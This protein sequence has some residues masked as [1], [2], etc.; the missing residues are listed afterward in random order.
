MIGST[1]T[2]FQIV[3]NGPTTFNGA[4]SLACSAGSTCAFSTNPIFVGSTT[5]MTI[6]NLN[7]GLP[8]PYAFTLTGTSGSQTS[9]LQLSLGFEDYTLTSTPA[10]QTIQA[11]TPGKFTIIVNPLNTFNQQVDLTC[12]NTGLPPDAT[13]TFSNSGPTPGPSSPSNVALTINTVKYV[14]PSHALPRLPNGTLPPLIFGL[15]SLA[16][17]ASLAL[18]NRRRAHPGWLAVRLAALSAILVLNLALA[19]CRSSTLTVSGTTTGNY[20]ITVSGTLHSNTAVVRTTTLNLAVTSSV[21]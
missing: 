16:G 2:T 7:T 19:A 15:L 1:Q 6:S 11:G 10:I 20:T 13:C 17:L 3:A 21:P 18:A 8:N 14:A 9:T 5:T 12:N 4:I